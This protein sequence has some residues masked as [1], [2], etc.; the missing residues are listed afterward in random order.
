MDTLPLRNQVAL[1]TGGGRRIGRVIAVTLAR[2]GARVVVNYH[3]SAREALATVRDIKAG[4]AE[5]VALRADVSNTR[6]VRAMFRAIERRF[7]RLDILV[8]NA[9]I[10][11]PA[12]WDKLTEHDWDRVLATN[13]KGPFFCAQ[14]AAR[15]MQ[16]QKRG[17]I[18]NIASLGGLQAWSEYM[19][20]CASKAGLI[21]L[22][23]C[24]AKALAPHI[25]VNSV[26]PGTIL[27]PGEKPD[28]LIQKV[29][30]RTPLKRAGRPED[31][32]ELVL[33]LATRGDFITGQVL[34]VDGGQAI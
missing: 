19:H 34:V 22:T 1:V 16:R 18:V 24:L 29:V 15:I 14:A 12:R 26:A 20:Y 7:G 11:F 2:A 32:A 23:R 33:Y 27:F 28:P 30:E 9:G 4:G 31:I 13:L 3:K 5:A 21:M 6:Q 17:R 25:Q 10:F 8:N